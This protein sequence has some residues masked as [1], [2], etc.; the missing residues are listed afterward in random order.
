MLNALAAAHSPQLALDCT[1]A[2]HFGSRFNVEARPA[3]A[4]VAL[5]RARYAPLADQLICAMRL[6][7]VC[8]CRSDGDCTAGRHERRGVARHCA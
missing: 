7:C 6:R 5:G 2:Y 3:G 1:R 4:D 8:V